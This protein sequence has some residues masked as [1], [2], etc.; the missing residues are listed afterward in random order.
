M[1]N[2]KIYVDQTLLE[3][4]HAAINAIL[5]PLR[6]CLCAELSVSAAACQ[7]AEIPI[8]GLIDQPLVNMEIQYLTTPD[9]TPTNITKAC[10]AFRDL[11]ATAIGSVPAVRATPLDPQTY[12]ALK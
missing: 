12:V 11:L 6:D 3:E 2:V 1:P 7:L 8:L 10:T 4:R 5:M 9:R